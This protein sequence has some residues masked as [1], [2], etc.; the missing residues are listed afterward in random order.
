MAIVRNGI[1]FMTAEE[2]RDPNNPANQ[3]LKAVNLGDVRFPNGFFIRD[4]NGKKY[5]EPA[6][7][8][9]RLKVLRT[10]M[11]DFPDVAPVEM[12]ACHHIGDES[13]GNG[14]GKLSPEFRCLKIHDPSIPF[15]GCGCVNFF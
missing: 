12:A 4:D 3:A 14:C 1:T 15:Y 13:C 6:T 2:A 7:W 9:D 5:V 11:P 10:A 8:E